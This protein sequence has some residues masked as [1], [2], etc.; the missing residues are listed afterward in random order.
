MTRQQIIA[1]REAAKADGWK[2][3]PTYRPETI[4]EDST[5]RRQGWTIIVTVRPPT[6]H[7]PDGVNYLHIWAPD[8]LAI[9]VPETYSVDALVAAMRECLECGAKD[10]NTYQV[11]FAGR[12]CKACL[13]AARAKYEYPGW[14]K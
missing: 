2:E 13:P 5:L 3:E 8:N 4:D 7:M 10:V 12:C 14:T 11:G 1:F 6:K 9:R